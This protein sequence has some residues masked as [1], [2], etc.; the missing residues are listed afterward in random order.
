MENPVDLTWRGK[1]KSAAD[2]LTAIQSRK[3]RGERVGDRLHGE[4]VVKQISTRESHSVQRL[5]RK[6]SILYMIV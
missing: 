6:N 2:W 4:I 3:K 1:E 5:E